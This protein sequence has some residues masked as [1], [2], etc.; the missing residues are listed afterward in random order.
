MY[1]VE[2][3]ITIFTHVPVVATCRLLL[4][5]LIPVDRDYVEKWVAIEVV[6]I[7]VSVG[8]DRLDVLHDVVD[9]LGDSDPLDY[10]RF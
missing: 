1:S 4:V 2:N 7:H 3:K 5:I 6:M 10:G 9:G 8:G